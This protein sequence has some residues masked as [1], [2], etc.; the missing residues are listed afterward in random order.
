[1][2]LGSSAGTSI[3][4]RERAETT[5]LIRTIGSWTRNRELKPIQSSFSGKNPGSLKDNDAGHRNW[6]VSNFLHKLKIFN[7]K[8]SPEMTHN[9]SS[10]RSVPTTSQS[11]E[12]YTRIEEPPA[13]WRYCQGMLVYHAL[14]AEK[15]SVAPKDALEFLESAKDITA[16][17]AICQDMGHQA[18]LEYFAAQW[19]LALWLE[20]LRQKGK[21]NLN[22][23]GGLHSYPIIIAAKKDN[24]N[25]F[26]SLASGP[27]LGYED[28][29]IYH[30]RDKRT[31]LHYAAMFPDS[32]VLEFLCNVGEVTDGNSVWI[33]KD[34]KGRTPLHLAALRGTVGN[35]QH[36]LRS[37]RP[38]S[39]PDSVD[40][41]VYRDRNG[42]TPIHLACL[43]TVPDVDICR[44]LVEAGFDHAEKNRNGN[45]PL[46]LAQKRR[47]LE[48][49]IYLQELD[50]P[51]AFCHPMTD[52][53]IRDS[54]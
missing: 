49:I 43:R 29:L 33:K 19:N 13:L 27:Y 42:N 10:D 41:I 16:L 11:L 35:V 14:A 48:I 24:L 32:K 53:P 17:E 4:A 25:A 47:N 50:D 7:R 54:D 38:F 52:S 12:H 44:M 6:L 15:E 3:H 28:F 18:T 30:D 20:Y 22:P 39:R 21:S 23:P 40:H 37:W 26:K 45:T 51:P 34:N 1:M 9:S 31:V 5:N 8:S 46:Q 36:L 2:S